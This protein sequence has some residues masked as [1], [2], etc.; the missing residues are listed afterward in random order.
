MG[1]LVWTSGMDSL[2]WL[3]IMSTVEGTEMRAKKTKEMNNDI[4]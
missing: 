2:S 3:P 4:I 1:P